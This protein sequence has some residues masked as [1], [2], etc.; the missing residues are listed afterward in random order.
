MTVIWITGLSGSGKT[1]IAKRLLEKSR[2]KSTCC[3]L[4]DGDEIR[5]ALS[6]EANQSENISKEDRINIAFKYSKLAQ[7]FEHQGCIV[8]V[9]TISL[10]KDIHDWNR[11]NLIDYIEIFLDVPIKDLIN[12]DPKGIYKAFLK[13]DL[14]NIAGL[15]VDID[16]PESPD[17]RLKCTFDT[18]EQSAQKILEFL[19]LKKNIEF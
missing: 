19:K 11:K 6:I 9:A 16:L 17:L 7:L 5:K 3:I 8:I 10:F 13:G 4:L 18:P 1:T 2:L 12:R 14:R 15:D